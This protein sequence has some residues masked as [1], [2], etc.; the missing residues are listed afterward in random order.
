MNYLQDYRGSP[1][2]HV[3]EYAQQIRNRAMLVL[4]GEESDPLDESAEGSMFVAGDFV[5]ESEC[6]Q[7]FPRDTF[8][9]LYGKLK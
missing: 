3:S 7:Y 4:L 5:W 1:E 8:W 2:S 6:A 9:F